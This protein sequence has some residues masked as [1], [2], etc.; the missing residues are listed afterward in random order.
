MLIKFLSSAPDWFALFNDEGK[1]DLIPLVGWAVMEDSLGD[2]V[3]GL[4]LCADN[5]MEMTRCDEDESFVAY[6]H[7]S[8]KERA[9]ELIEKDNRISHDKR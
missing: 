2:D 7:G 8:E 9:V 4:V 5:N 1:P 3:V 6:L